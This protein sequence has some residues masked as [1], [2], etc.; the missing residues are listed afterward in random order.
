[1]RVPLSLQKYLFKFK[2][3]AFNLKPIVLKMFKS[4]KI[5]E[6]TENTLKI[7]KRST[8]ERGERRVIYPGSRILKGG[9]V[10]KQKNQ[11]KKSGFTEF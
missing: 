4:S 2:S 6:V 3:Q 10:Y 1:M 5:F 11:E 7:V 8:D 9:P